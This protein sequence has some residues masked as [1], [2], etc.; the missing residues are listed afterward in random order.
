MPTKRDLDELVDA[1]DHALAYVDADD[2][3]ERLYDAVRPFL[4]EKPR[5][6]RLWLRVL[7][8]LLFPVWGVPFGLGVICFFVWVAVNEQFDRWEKD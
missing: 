2:V 8:A 6:K 4:D 1:A 5:P 7:A 3:T